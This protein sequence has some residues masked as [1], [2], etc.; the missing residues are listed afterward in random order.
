MYKCFRSINKSL[1]KDLYNLKKE[2]SGISPALFLSG[3]GML[4][5]GGIVL[6]RAESIEDKDEASAQKSAAFAQMGIGASL[7]ITPFIKAG[8]KTAIK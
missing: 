6:A 4:L 3:V 2:T 7:T 5:S 1:I 8:V